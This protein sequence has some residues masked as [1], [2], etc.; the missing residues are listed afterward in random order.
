MI[1]NYST[2]ILAFLVLAVILLTFPSK[3]R[4]AESSEQTMVAQVGSGV[5]GT[6]KNNPEEY[7][8]EEF[9]EDMWGDSK[10]N[11]EADASDPWQGYNRAMFKFND[12]MYFNVMKP[13]TKGYKWLVPLRPRTWT[14]NFFQN[15]LYPVRFAS[16]VLQGK[17]YTAGAETSKFVANSIFGLGGLGNVVGEAQSTMPL[18][19]GDEDMGQTFGVWGIPNGTY[20]V[21]PLLGPSTVRDAAGFGIDTF[22]LNPFWWFGIPWYYSASAGAYNQINKLSFHI[23]E[24]ESLKEGSIDPYL[25][26]RD[27]YLSFRAKQIH[28]AKIDPQKPEPKMTTDPDATPQN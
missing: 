23:G 13:V 27:A 9:S 10:T 8:D 6:V 14:N 2:T 24:Y 15:M 21:L 22:V 3:V 19:L 1:R 5:I 26:L 7:A 18:Y 25:A 4:S 11:E 12:Y 16:C 28:D 17:F 20:F